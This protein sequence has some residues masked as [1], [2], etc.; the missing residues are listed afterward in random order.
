MINMTKINMVSSEYWKSLIYDFKGLFKIY[1][2]Q[3]LFSL[4]VSVI[5]IIIGFSGGQRVLSLVWGISY[6]LGTNLLLLIVSEKI[7]NGWAQNSVTA[8]VLFG[9]STDRLNLSGFYWILKGIV[10]LF[11]YIFSPFLLLIGLFQYQVI[12][13]KIIAKQELEN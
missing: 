13:N 1:P 2:I 5:T 7:E 11:K 3:V 8:H 9:T 4:I 6:F 12:L 10:V